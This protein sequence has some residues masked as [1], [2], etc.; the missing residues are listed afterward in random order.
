MSVMCQMRRERVCFCPCINTC[1]PLSPPPGLSVGNM[2]Y[3][4]SDE[5]VT[6]LQ[7][8]E[9]E[10]RRHMKRSERIVATYV[11]SAFNVTVPERAGGGAGGLIWTPLLP[12]TG[13]VEVN[14]KHLKT[15]CS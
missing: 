2:F 8:G 9:C 10:I 3:V 14:A 4:F 7:P 12:R 11:S 5:G 13:P 15:S 6:A 1:L